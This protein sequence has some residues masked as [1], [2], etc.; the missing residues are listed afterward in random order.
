MGSSRNSL[1]ADLFSRLHPSTDERTDE[2]AD[3]RTGA[4]LAG[5]L[6]GWLVGPI[7]ELLTQLGDV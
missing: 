6:V 2:R 5:W 1:S 7:R 3:E 4:R